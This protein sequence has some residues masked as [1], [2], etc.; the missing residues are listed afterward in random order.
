MAT[1]GV[2][3]GITGATGAL[4][5][6]VLAALDASRLRIA[7]LVAVAGD[8]SL[9]SDIEFQSD[10]VPVVTELPA[11][12]GLDLLLNC[13]PPA[14]APDIARAALRAEVPCI[15]LSGVF[16]QRSEVPLSWVAGGDPIAAGP[17]LASP[18]DAALVW[19]PLLRSLA[20]LGP[21]ASVTGTILEAASAAGRAGI[22]ALSLE[23]MALF[24]Q[25]E[26]PERDVPSRSL[27]FD[28]H[29]TSGELVS[30]RR[31]REVALAAALA[32]CLGS[33]L[34][35]SARWIQVPA[36]V[37]QVSS[38]VIAWER[39]V[40]PAEAAL[41]L[42]KAPG[43]ELWDGALEAPNLR[44]VAGR[45]VVVASRPEPDAARPGALRLWAAGD[46]LRLA[47]ANAVALAIGLLSERGA[48]E[49]R[50]AR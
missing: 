7:Q 35:V 2:R 31:T 24:N 37:G 34:A 38:L 46:V 19:L 26:L 11:L 28:C 21:L 43:V 1:R 27:A 33:T 25:Q 9:G 4:G 30:G 20:E 14:A 36:F 50:G 6:E 16:A 41:R 15:D 49:S 17:L 32:R 39:P 22:E 40:E 23:S 48:L 13:A 29:A 12:H 45:D 5:T 10:V 47:A 3:L 8:G 44:A 42:A 18:V